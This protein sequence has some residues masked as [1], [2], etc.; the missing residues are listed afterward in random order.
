[1]PDKLALARRLAEVMRY[2][3][4]HYAPGQL[5]HGHLTPYNV[6]VTCTEEL[7]V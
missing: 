4:E 5:L 2:V 6:F 1:M 3:H 7:G